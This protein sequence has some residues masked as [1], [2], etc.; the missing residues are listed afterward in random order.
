MREIKLKTPIRKKGN[1]IILHIALTQ[2]YAA[3]FP[4]QDSTDM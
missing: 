2:K 3:L 4:T 1:H